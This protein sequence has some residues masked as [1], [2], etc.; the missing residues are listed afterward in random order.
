MASH[1]GKWG[2]VSGSV[3]RGERL[4][5]AAYREIFEEVSIPENALTFAAKIPPFDV[6][7]GD[8]C[9]HVHSFLFY[10]ITDIVSLNEENTSYIWIHPD[11]MSSFDIVPGLY[12]AYRMLIEVLNP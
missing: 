11:S 12:D 3:H 6:S 1:P 8:I 4:L 7:E 10:S 2:A 9:W 5:E